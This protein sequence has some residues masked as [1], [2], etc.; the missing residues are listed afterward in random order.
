MPNSFATT[1]TLNLMS[2][3]GVLGSEPNIFPLITK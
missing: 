1:Q 3:V 2:I